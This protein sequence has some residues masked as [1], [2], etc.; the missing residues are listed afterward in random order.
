MQLLSSSPTDAVESGAPAIASLGIEA[1]LGFLQ[2]TYGLFTVGIGVSAVGAFAGL[3]ALTSGAYPM[4]SPFV[5]LIAYLVAFF[6]VYAVRKV[7][8]VNVVALLAFTFVSGLMMAPLLAYTLAAKGVA[9]GL[10]NIMTAFVGATLAFGGLSAYVFISR[11][12]F[13][14]LGGFLM[15]MMFGI[16][17][18]VICTWIFGA[19]A[20][21]AIWIAFNVVG[22][23]VMC[24]FVLY[25]TSMIL[26]HY[27][28]DEYVMAA[29]ALFLDF[30]L[31]FKYLLRLLNSR[32]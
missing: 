15:V 18:F 19:P 2:K 7:P 32:D 12:D 26:H 21:P 31:I 6:A 16:I 10:A 13:S 24:G 28:E 4:M 23:T 11:K 27:A 3:Q 29:L 22:L 14:Y 30:I 5:F 17:G 20:N 8:V 1:R 9:V 25:D